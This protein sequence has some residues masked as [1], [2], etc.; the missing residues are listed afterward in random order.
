M[1]KVVRK[2]GKF[3]WTTAQRQGML[4]A[5]DVKEAKEFNVF[6]PPFTEKVNSKQTVQ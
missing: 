1:S 2:K 6:F 3:V 4:S 5:E